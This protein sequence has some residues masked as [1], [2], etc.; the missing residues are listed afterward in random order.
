MVVHFV[1]DLR[2][3]YSVLWKNKIHTHR[4]NMNR[5]GSHLET[6]NLST[7]GIIANFSLFFLQCR[8]TARILKCNIFV[9]FVES[10]CYES[11]ENT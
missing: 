9:L 5:M 4:I 1:C 3:S 7:I 2:S 6:W 8:D 10:K 11:V